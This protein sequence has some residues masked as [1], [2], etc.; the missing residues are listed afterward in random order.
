MND[1]INTLTRFLDGKR[2][3]TK[4]VYKAM[5]TIYFK[6]V[7][8]NGDTSTNNPVNQVVESQQV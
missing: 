3:V 1:F 8:N 7:M 4:K 6:E 2:D 5:K